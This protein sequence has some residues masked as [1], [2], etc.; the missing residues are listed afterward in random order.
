MQESLPWWSATR[1]VLAAAII[2]ACTLPGRTHG[3]GIITTRLLESFEGLGEVGLA[4][5]N[6]V[7][8][9]VGSLL[10]IPIGW[11][12]DRVR[13][14]TVALVCILGLGGAVWGMCQSHTL[15]ALAI[16]I[17][18][19]RAIGQSMLS[20]IS[21]AVIGKSFPRRPGAIMGG[22]AIVMTM[23]MAVW[24]GYLAW[25][26]SAM[27]WR[28]TWE[29]L[30]YGLF[31]LGPV[32]WL[33]SW[34]L[35]GAI[36]PRS[37]EQSSHVGSVSSA[38][39]KQALAT[40]CFWMF[41]ICISLFGMISAGLSLFQQ[42][43]FADRGIEESIYHQVLVLGLLVGLIAN[44]LGGYLA[45]KMPL[46]VLQG[47]AMLLLAVSLAALPFLS[48]TMHAYSFCIVYSAGGGILTVLFFTVWGQAFGTR[49]LGSIQGA[50]QILTVIASAAGPL[51][52]AQSHAQLGS[53]RPVLL[54]YV[55][56]CVL[57][58]FASLTIRVPSAMDGDWQNSESLTP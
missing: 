47:V 23:M 57:L 36:S 11:L 27:P 51:L 16:S 14:S 35:P 4:N 17:T 33:L 22:Y 54:T 52:F 15:L 8:T 45:T 28:V 31:L 34:N 46:Q 18:L 37:D 2:M 42:S 48:T 40:P 20:V 5:I 56:I 3:M 9:L 12:L 55:S 38:T 29:E 44:L 7:A 32:V 50:A 53:Y 30:S 10:C 43:I 24:T 6:L 25:R 26:V 39:L 1:A 13:I 58:G 41:S 21:L 19:T 49:S